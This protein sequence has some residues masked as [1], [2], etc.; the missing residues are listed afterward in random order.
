MG[1]E[2][3]DNAGVIRAWEEP[4]QP[5]G[6]DRIPAPHRPAGCREISVFAGATCGRSSLCRRRHRSALGTNNRHAHRQEGHQDLAENRRF[7]DGAETLD[8][9]QRPDRYAHRSQP[10]SCPSQR[11][12]GRQANDAT[13]AERRSGECAGS[14]N[15][16]RHSGSRPYRV[17]RSDAAQR[18]EDTVTAEGRCGGCAAS[19]R[20][21]EQLSGFQRDRREITR[22]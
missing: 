16:P 7:P 9:R 15:S 2:T 6:K 11:E 18:A 20:F 21:R 1:R 8:C 14:A 10:A 5:I 12:P 3:G 13:I 17:E 19:L 22:L 4:H